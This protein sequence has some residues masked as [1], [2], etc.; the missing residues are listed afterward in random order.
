MS[1]SIDIKGYKVLRTL[2]QGGMATVYLAVQESF[3][4][5]VA[6][7]VMSPALSADPTF[8]ERFLREAR[9]VSRLVHPNIVTVYDVGVDN[10]YHFLS[11]EY[12]PGQ[13]LKDQRFALS[14][15]ARLR[16]IKEVASALDFA[17]S[18]GY[19]HRDVKP[20]N[21]MLHARDSRAVLMDF[22]IARPADGRSSMTQT[23][24][25]IG[26][27]HY[28]SPEQ[29]KGRE[30]DARSDLYSLGVVLYLLL[31]GQVPF[32]ADSAVAVG[33]KHVSEPVPRLSPELALFQPIIDK[34]LAKD[35]EARYQTGGELIA[36]L[37]ALPAADIA[38]LAT[39]LSTTETNANVA[40]EDSEAPTVVNASQS[41]SDTGEGTGATS[42][43]TAVAPQVKMDTEAALVSAESLA[44]TPEDL[45]ERPLPRQQGS[46]VATWLLGL[47]VAVATGGGFYWAQRIPSD[48]QLDVTPPSSESR[49]P[50]VAVATPSIG[51]E[52]ASASFAEP[53]AVETTVTEASAMTGVDVEAASGRSPV[54][55]QSPE[56]QEVPAEV[57]AKALA[58]G[59]VY[60]AS[61][62]RT[63]DM[64]S[65]PL[66][67]Q[68]VPAVSVDEQAATNSLVAK[69]GQSDTESDG[70]VIGADVAEDAVVEVAAGTEAAVILDSEAHDAS[71][72]SDSHPLPEA[73]EVAENAN[74]S[75]V[76]DVASDLA[77]EMP[78]QAAVIAAKI[79]LARDY[80]AADALTQP[81]G[82]NALEVFSQV[83]ALQ[84]EHAEALAGLQAI[85]ERYLQLS[86]KPAAEGRW[87]QALDLIDK[88]LD[89]VQD[90]PEL[91]PARQ[92]VEAAQS[93]QERM[94]QLLAQARELQQAGQLL[95]PS[96]NSAFDRYR[97]VLA[98]S[99]KHPVLVELQQQAREQ[100]KALEAQVDQALAQLLEA[101]ELVELEAK[102]ALAQQKFPDSALLEARQLALDSAVEA[103]IQAAIEASRPKVPT[104]VVSS[105]QLED[106][107]VAQASTLAADRTIHIGFQ[108]ENFQQAT[109]VVQAILFD[110]AR[111]LQ[112]AQV[113]VVVTG[114]GG[115]KFF[116][117]DRPVEG[118]AEGGY[119]IDLL[120][121]GDR[122]S[123]VTF[124]VG[125]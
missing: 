41:M 48:L 12:V 10:G 93:G 63:Q 55:S 50:Q 22:G 112:I 53:V 83:L 37:D 97:A 65:G 66:G 24:I 115:V 71:E 23:G 87:Q 90:H 94:K 78:D 75:P 32:D 40:A 5:E 119:N 62:E 3:E 84:P 47:L 79:T 86:H 1:T 122:L 31:E 64:A 39:Q 74:V 82:A 91:A 58:S 70:S 69:G 57:Q 56:S 110:G 52:E 59:S 2:G 120:L 72:M 113:P 89:V 20:E 92:A 77:G 114:K 44:V 19:V 42:N 29:A 34:V 54:G 26:T 14:L 60:A 4:R 46:G 80:L 18:Q 38:E 76:A 9:I 13:D 33:I 121:G 15:P 96:D 105:S 81:A 85:A 67:T 108:Y 99:V 104:V 88:G 118:F 25:A 98:E 35:P 36:A 21:I 102:L 123:S 117:I 68:S 17:G 95:Q 124:K 7:K 16:V 6:L 109:S 49:L 51:I 101:G 111:S 43:P 11:M 106:I 27:P 107:D 28:M 103:E 116:R 125:K 61:P 30:V 73:A 100:L 8:G 45:Q